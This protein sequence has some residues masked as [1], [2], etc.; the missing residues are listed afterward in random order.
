MLL[1]WAARPA[2]QPRRAAAAAVAAAQAAVTQAMRAIGGGLGCHIASAFG[3]SFG[4]YTALQRLHVQNQLL[5]LLLLQ[6]WSL[7][8][9]HV[10]HL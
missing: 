9:L 3:E 5:L 7:Q 8:V 1:P 6:R 2:L 10:Y 4:S